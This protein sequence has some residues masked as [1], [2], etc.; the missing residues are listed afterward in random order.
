MPVA[1][2]PQ[3]GCQIATDPVLF[4]NS[5]AFS[6]MGLPFSEIVR[7]GNMLYLSGRM[8]NLPGTLML[9]PGGID[10][11]ARQTLQNIKTSLQA[12]GYSMAH[13]VKCTVMLADMNDWPVF[14]AV[15]TSFFEPPYPAR[16]AFGASGLALGGRL[17][18]DV[19]ACA[20]R[21]GIP[22]PNHN[23]EGDIR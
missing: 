13:I 4:L 3:S 10:A 23:P 16:S 5:S 7:V 15:Y 1:A 6:A 9:A 21:R 12:H 18:L 22:F 8:G 17:E 2:T 14:N 20:D 19:I 11:Q